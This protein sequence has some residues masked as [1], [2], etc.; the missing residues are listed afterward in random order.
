MS[1]SDNEDD[2]GDDNHDDDG[3]SDD[4]YDDDGDDDHDEDGDNETNQ[5]HHH[6]WC[7]REGPSENFPSLSPYGNLKVKIP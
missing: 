7:K 6:S 3:D 1:V 2:D 5:T 4:D